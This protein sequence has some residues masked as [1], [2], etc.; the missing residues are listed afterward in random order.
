MTSQNQR[1]RAAALFKTESIFQGSIIQNH[2]THIFVG[3]RDS[4]FWLVAVMVQNLSPHPHPD[5]WKKWKCHKGAMFLTPKSDTSSMYKCHM[6]LCGGTEQGIW[7][8][9]YQVFIPSHF[10]SSN[11]QGLLWFG[12]V[13]WYLSWWGWFSGC[14][15]SPPIF[16][17]CL[18]ASVLRVL[19]FPLTFLT[20]KHRSHT[21]K[22]QS[23]YPQHL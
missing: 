13:T 18:S 17:Q 4:G 6:V 3:S 8:F 20:L 10:C 16:L 14:L 12:F 15:S 19:P 11:P 23:R 1:P 2:T 22:R 9:R 21:N 7:G 5:V